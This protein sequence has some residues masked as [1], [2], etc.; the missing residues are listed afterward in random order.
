MRGEHTILWPAIGGSVLCIL[1]GFTL[2]R[3]A[4]EQ[5]LR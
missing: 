2:A 3:S 1:A 4:P 5:E